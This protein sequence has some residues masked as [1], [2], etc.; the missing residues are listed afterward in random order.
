MHSL[1]D[2]QGGKKGIFGRLI[3]VD[4]SEYPQE[5]FA[6]LPKNMYIK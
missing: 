3:A 6:G 5:W 2:E 4:H 1:L